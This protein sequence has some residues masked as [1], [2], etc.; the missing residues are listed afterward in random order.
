MRNFT[1]LYGSRWQTRWG[2][3][4]RASLFSH[5]C[6]PRICR[7]MG[8]R[9]LRVSAPAS[10]SAH[11]SRG[12]TL[13]RHLPDAFVS[14]GAVLGIGPLGLLHHRVRHLPALLLARKSFAE[15]NCCR[16]KIH[17]DRFGPYGAVGAAAIG[18]MVDL[19]IGDKLYPPIVAF[20]HS[21]RT[22]MTVAIARHVPPNNPFFA[23]ARRLCAITTCGCC[24]AACP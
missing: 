2:F 17:L 14:A 13:H 18:W 7:G 10:D 19:Q 5:S 23:N 16:F 1:E 11:D 22:A 8:A 15:Y 12:P 20:D 6:L 21:V 24:F 9:P 3:S 4:R